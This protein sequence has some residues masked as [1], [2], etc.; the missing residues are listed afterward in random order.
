MAY[1]ACCLPTNM[2]GSCSPHRQATINFIVPTFWHTRSMKNKSQ[3]LIGTAIEADLILLRMANSML[4]S[5]PHRLSVACG[6]R[7][8]TPDDPRPQAVPFDH[9]SS[10]L[11]R[12]ARSISS[13]SSPSVRNNPHIGLMTSL[14]T[15]RRDEYQ[16]KATTRGTCD[17]P[18]RSRGPPRLSS[19]R[20]LPRPMP[21]MLRTGTRTA[22]HETRHCQI[23]SSLRSGNVGIGP[24]R[25]ARQ[26]PWSLNCPGVTQGEDSQFRSLLSASGRVI[27][28]PEGASARLCGNAYNRR[29]G[30]AIS[31]ASGTCVHVNA[32]LILTCDDG[33]AVSRAG[34]V[35]GKHKGKTDVSKV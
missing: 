23:S 3:H 18:E 19:P 2:A 17:L 12:M 35:R 10:M 22:T 11:R 25:D 21:N 31:N 16:P 34:L 14:H 32:T 13:S 33:P 6:A 28:T 30:C 8:D 24:A 9:C 15:C 4:R 7:R 26:L 5:L 20:R 29:T 1:T 27:A